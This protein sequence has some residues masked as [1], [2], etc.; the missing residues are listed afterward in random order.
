MPIAPPLQKMA[1][2]I[3]EAAI[4]LGVKARDFEHST[5]HDH[6][7]CKMMRGP[8]N[9]LMADDDGMLL[10]SGVVEKKAHPS[11]VDILLYVFVHPQP[12][13]PNG[14]LEMYV[15]GTSRVDAVGGPPAFK[16][17][18]RAGCI[19]IFYKRVVFSM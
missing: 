5:M 11:A 9:K 6:D 12:G 19:H 3:R 8:G 1:A 16:E 10:Y 7:K 4:R 15:D 17:V 18:R 13:M 2:A 14:F